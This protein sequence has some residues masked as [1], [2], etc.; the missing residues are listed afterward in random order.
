MTS[1]GLRCGEGVKKK[2]VR[3]ES[4][5]SEREKERE[6]EKIDNESTRE[7]ERRE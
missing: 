6:R 7:C 2:G 5:R 4:E 3:M 1:R